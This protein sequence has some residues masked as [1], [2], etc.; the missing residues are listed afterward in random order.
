MSEE[1]SA[2]AGFTGFT[3]FTGF[4]PLHTEIVKLREF[5]G[6]EIYVQWRK[7]CGPRES[8]EWYCGMTVTRTNSTEGIHMSIKVFEI[9]KRPL[10][11]RRITEVYALTCYG[12]HRTVEF[13][14]DARQRCPKCDTPLEVQWLEGRA[15][16]A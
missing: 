12:C 6:V 16:A 2:P 7:S 10:R 13:P 15:A 9:E 14:T 4:F 5:L 11:D 3:R 8:C 1:T